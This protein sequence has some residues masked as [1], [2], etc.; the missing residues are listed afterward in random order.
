MKIGIIGYGSFTREIIN[1]IKIPFDI[2]VNNDYYDK[3]YNNIH[4]IE[5]RHKCRLY[6]INNFDI[7]KY[8]A[9]ITIVDL[10]YRK[11]IIEMLPINTNYISYIDKYARILNKKSVKLGKSNIICAG[12]I[13]TTDINIGDF[14]QINLNTTIGHDCNIGS[15]FTS[16]PNV[17]IS[18]NCNIGNNV[19]IGTNSS[20][21]EKI[22]VCDNVICGLNTGIVKSIDIEG[23]YIGTPAI[24]I[25]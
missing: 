17:S 8:H 20:I 22:S 16:A 2:F 21:R 12:S 15:F 14:S 4:F 5:N 18:G 9:L 3:I 11:E 6:K 1:G 24:K 10:K 23:L 13:L 25:K 7:H 19:Y